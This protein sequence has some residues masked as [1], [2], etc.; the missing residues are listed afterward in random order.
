VWL[1]TEVSGRL[2]PGRRWTAK[3]AKTRA[4][5]EALLIQEVKKI[6]ECGNVEGFAITR[7]L[8]RPWDIAIVGDGPHVKPDCWKKMRQIAHRLSEQY[9]LSEA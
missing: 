2:I 9:D 8:G 4:E 5:L 6:T 7:P 1:E 3:E